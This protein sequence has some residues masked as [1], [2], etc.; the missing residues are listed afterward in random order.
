MGQVLTVPSNKMIKHRLKSKYSNIEKFGNKW[1]LLPKI[2]YAIPPIIQSLILIHDINTYPMGK[3]INPEI[4]RN[5]M[6]WSI[7]FC[8]TTILFSV[9]SIKEAVRIDIVWKFY[10]K[11]IEKRGYNNLVFIQ[12]NE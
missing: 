6:I 3:S 1:N 2:L 4:A 9:F 10:L 5:T 11:K 12:N 8:L 7:L